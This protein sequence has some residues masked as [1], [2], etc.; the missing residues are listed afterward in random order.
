MG[1]SKSRNPKMFASEK[2]G[3]K[4]YTNEEPFHSEKPLHKAFGIK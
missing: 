1:L 2:E 3:I 4:V